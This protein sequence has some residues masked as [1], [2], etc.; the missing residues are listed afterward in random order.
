VI[1]AAGIQLIEVVLLAGNDSCTVAS[2]IALPSV[3]DGGLGHDFLVGGGGP[4]ILIGGPGDDRLGGGGRRNLL[5]G[6]LDADRLIGN[7]SDDI[8]IAG[9]TSYDSGPDSSK[10]ANDAI[11]MEL[12][13][14][15]NSARSY[16][17]RI[18]NLRAGSGPILGASGNSLSKGTTVIDDS[19]FDKLTGS[20]GSDWFL[21]DPIGDLVT[22]L[23]SKEIVN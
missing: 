7:G 16:V 11:L 10:L 8:L 23:S 14:E 19:F 18:A 2:S 22:D 15:W 20:A 4:N 1:P 13:D 5:I 12:G 9:Y 17:Q 3:I 6:G 21:F